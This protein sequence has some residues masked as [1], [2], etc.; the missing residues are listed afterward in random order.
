MAGQLSDNSDIRNALA[1]IY[2]HFQKIAEVKP[3][4]VSFSEERSPDPAQRPPSPAHQPASPAQDNSALIRYVT[5]IPCN[6][7]DVSGYSTNNLATQTES[8]PDNKVDDRLS[9]LEEDVG[10]LRTEFL[11]FKQAVSDKLESLERIVLELQEKTSNIS[12]G[13]N[14][15]GTNNTSSGSANDAD[16]SSGRS[17]NS[18]DTGSGNVISTTT[19]ENNDYMSIRNA[20]TTSVTST[21]TE[22]IYEDPGDF[23]PGSMPRYRAPSPPS[24]PRPSIRHTESAPSGL[25]NAATSSSS[26]FHQQQQ[27]QQ[28]QIVRGSKRQPQQIAS[29]T[30]TTSPLSRVVQASQP[31]AQL[32]TDD[33]AP[34]PPPRTA[35]SS[36][37]MN[38]PN[39]PKSNPPRRPSENPG[40]KHSLQG[41]NS[42]A[43]LRDNF[44]NIA[45]N[46]ENFRQ[47]ASDNDRSRNAA[48]LRSASNP[49]P[50]VPPAVRPRVKP[51][52]SSVGAPG[53]PMGTEPET[54]TDNLEE[55][56]VRHE[57][58]TWAIRGIRTR[59]GLDIHTD[60]SDTLVIGSVS[61]FVD[62][63]TQIQTVE[64]SNKHLSRQQ[65]VQATNPL[66]VA[67][68][69]NT[70]HSIM[71]T[72]ENMARF[73]AATKRL[74]IQS[75]GL[76]LECSLK[77]Q[78]KEQLLVRLDGTTTA[79]GDRAQA[80]SSTRQQRPPPPPPQTL[81]MSAPATATA[82]ASAAVTRAHIC[83][84][85]L[86]RDVSDDK[87]LV[88]GWML[89]IFQPCSVMLNPKE[90][91]KVKG[92]IKLLVELK[93]DDLRQSH[94]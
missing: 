68:T 16:T 37:A 64:N 89:N 61:P 91:F 57:A 3:T 40:P 65:P 27:Q 41:S 8:M 21:G 44:Q 90:L 22:H 92:L 62:T 32:L 77:L 34:R 33:V 43:Q 80:P 66:S 53:F 78:S 42:V 19:T 23:Y 56:L 31:L 52:L 7:S 13:T 18:N 50:S 82:A 28:Q 51:R 9:S 49:N 45:M 48:V 26:S 72:I 86:G 46:N 69:P 39:P 17:V 55:D 2:R 94:C 35:A 6:S 14:L 1:G 20:T 75:L 58:G 74:A 84:I 67:P 93:I 83:V 73:K 85:H 70:I 29:S 4:N 79:G 59:P 76:D 47:V 38:S 54:W 15:T 24:N 25:F 5:K 88:Q 60:E 10:K 30:A 87:I 11:D 81:Q 12:D 36:T 63:R 71:F